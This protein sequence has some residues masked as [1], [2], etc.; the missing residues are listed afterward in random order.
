MNMKPHVQPAGPVPA[1]ADLERAAALIAGADALVIAAG[2]GMGVDSG[3]PD[4][5]GNAGFWRSY[6]ALAAGRVG[7]MDIASPRAFDRDPRR[8]W[9]FY[10]HRLALYRDAAPHAGYGLLWRWAQALPLGGFVFTSNVDGHFQRAG[11]DPLRIDEC[12]GSIH[13]LQCQQPCC[14][15]VWPASALAPAVDV[16]RCAWEGALPACPHCGNG[17]RPNI[18]MF[19]DVRWLDGRR[20]AQAL[21]RQRWLE[22]VRRPV[23]VEIGAGL[24]VPTVRQFAQRVVRERSGALVRINPHEAG[25]GTLPGVGL[26]G[27][28]L[29]TLAALDAL[30]GGLHR[31]A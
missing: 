25:I 4:F 15:L 24:N 22:Q 23:V 27:S 30:L 1:R 8:A 16:A 7:F 3:L 31:P 19:D 29:A 5:R 28:A 9:G 11:F 17:A 14:D 2:A 13:W 12:H 26:A 6:P 20:D 18:L 10:G 21:R